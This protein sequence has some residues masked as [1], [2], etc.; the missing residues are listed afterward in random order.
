MVFSFLFCKV[1]HLLGLV[2]SILKYKID[3]FCF[4]FYKS[5]GAILVICV[6]WVLIRS[7]K[8]R[9]GI[10]CFQLISCTNKFTHVT[11]P[12]F[13]SLVFSLESGGGKEKC[14]HLVPRDVLSSTLWRFLCSIWHWINPLKSK[15]SKICS[16]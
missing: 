9:R 16:Y 15:M 10:P 8:S 11:S 5:M 7:P 12:I 4:L 14:E 3:F 13:F 1:S 2:L 6:L